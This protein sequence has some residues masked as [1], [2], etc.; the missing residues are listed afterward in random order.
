M[1]EGPIYR[2]LFS[3]D[4][5]RDI[6]S[7]DNT[8]G[9][10]LEVEKAVCAEQAD[11]GLVPQKAANALA[12]ITADRLDRP[13]LAVDM[14]L[15][16][17]PIVGL[18]KQLRE[19]VGPPADQSIHKGITTQDLMDT[20]MIM[21]MA[22]SLALI[23]AELDR[24]LQ[25]L[26]RLDEAHGST[27]MIGRTNGQHALPM[28]FGQK[29]A[30]WSADL[31]RRRASLASAA[32]RGL[33][34]QLG[35]PVGNLSAFDPPTALNLR[36]GVARRLGLRPPTVH[37]QNARDGIAE[38]VQSV[39]LLGASLCR[40]AHNV[41]ALSATDI[42]EL[43]EVSCTGQG[44]SSS[45]AHKQNQRA[46]EFAEAL[47][48]LTRQRAEQIGEVTLHEHERSGGVWIAEWVIVPETFLKASGALFWTNRMLDSLVVDQDL[49]A[50][51][52]AKLAS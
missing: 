25:A 2:D 49:M 31:S 39:G 1:L 51:N 45:M 27:P 47:G 5:M 11:L 18:T 17:R 28:T 21:Q 44:A 35:G 7:E 32:D 16:G 24:A 29:L 19:Q 4:Q 10:W 50:D 9:L 41:N 13:R 36:E 22:A 12:A 8:V 40:I 26:E 33:W 3:T 46:S 20:A 48:R 14:A 15:A 38:I 30:A 34:L 23:D 52:L 42:G 43:R 6:W 37:W